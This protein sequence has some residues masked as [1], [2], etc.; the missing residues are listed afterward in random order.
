MGHLHNAVEEH[1]ED[2]EEADLRAEGSCSGALLHNPLI[3]AEASKKMPPILP[4]D[5]EQQSSAT[6]V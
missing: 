3:L 5:L 1:L 4:A 6:P 2:L